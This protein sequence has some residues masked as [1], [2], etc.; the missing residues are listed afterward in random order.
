M[1]VPSF[2]ALDPKIENE[3]HFFDP[4]RL[5]DT[6]G[7][8]LKILIN[9]VEG[10]ISFTYCGQKSAQKLYNKTLLT[11]VDH[12]WEPSHRVSVAVIMRTDAFAKVT[13][14][15]YSIPEKD[16]RNFLFVA[17]FCPKA[18]G[19]LPYGLLREIAEFI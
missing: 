18:Y 12:W 10:S 11:D 1:K 16:I 14:K 6:V 2:L 19:N 13:F 9:R 8:K 15:G 7:V 4:N 5:F 17:K 3:M